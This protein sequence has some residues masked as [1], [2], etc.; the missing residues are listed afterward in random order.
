M[1][2]SIIW[3]QLNPVSAT[4]LLT[5]VQIEKIVSSL[6]TSSIREWFTLE[7]WAIE[8]PSLLYEVTRA[9]RWFLEAILWHSCGVKMS[10]WI[11]GFTTN[12]LTHQDRT[13][14]RRKCRIE[15]DMTETEQ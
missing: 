3:H 4:Y 13:E 6:A 14:G 11:T 7:L 10:Q 1:R 5:G 8:V 15:E 12:T 2:H 9:H